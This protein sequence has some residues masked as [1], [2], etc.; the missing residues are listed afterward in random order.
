MKKKLYLTIALLAAPAVCG[1]A[2]YADIIDGTV[3]YDTSATSCE[4]VTAGDTA[5][6]LEGAQSAAGVAGYLTICP[7]D[8]VGT[9]LASDS[10]MLLTKAGLTITVMG[11]ATLD[12]D[13]VGANVIVATGIDNVTILGG[14]IV[15]GAT[16][17]GIKNTE[18]DSWEITGVTTTLNGLYGVLFM[19]D[20]GT[21]TDLNIH[22]MTSTYNGSATPLGAQIYLE[23]KTTAES[24]I[25][26]VINISDN[27]LSSQY[28][29]TVIGRHAI[30]VYPAT[31]YV[32]GS[33]MTI[34]RNSGSGFDYSPIL[35]AKDV[36]GGDVGFNTFYD[37]SANLIHFGGTAATAGHYTRNINAHDNILYDTKL[38]G[39]TDSS[40]ILFDAYSENNATSRNRISNYGE[41]CLK[42]NYSSGNV[43]DHDVCINLKSDGVSDA[44]LEFR[45]TT[46]LYSGPSSSNIVYNLTAIHSGDTNSQAGIYA[47]G[48]SG[49]AG[50][51]IV[52]SSIFINPDGGDS[53]V[54]V[55]VQDDAVLTE[56][57][58]VFYNFPTDANGHTLAETDITDN[59]YLSTTGKPTAKSPTAVKRGGLLLDGYASIAGKWNYMGA[60]PYYEGT[61]TLWNIALSIM[62][63]PGR[64]GG[65]K[66]YDESGSYML[67][68]A[69]DY[70]LTET[71]DKMVM[72]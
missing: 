50:A 11:G 56:D 52:S 28:T 54:G 1:A 65:G 13:G 44:V 5:S 49:E 23:A 18:G 6:D 2:T 20:D 59:P 61:I 53:L 35:F 43:S 63:G 57:H 60:Y 34:M 55:L 71:G 30:A 8:Y 33:Q 22:H 66:I 37:C 27:T 40:G 67:M 58:N 45:G 38:D 42:Y 19:A 31:G 70:M 25:G 47:Y 69:G 24:Y 29:P 32:D 15:T 4:D 14:G 46:G 64:L 48:Q 68:E 7:G 12:S 10:S 39:G 9:A 62:G 51:N 21:I 72:E 16:A 3:Y 26:G 36:N 41:S 17:T